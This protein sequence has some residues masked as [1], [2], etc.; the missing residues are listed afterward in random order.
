MNIGAHKFKL[1]LEI[2]LRIKN[3]FK[4]IEVISDPSQ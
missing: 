2:S 4:K 3:E 1:S